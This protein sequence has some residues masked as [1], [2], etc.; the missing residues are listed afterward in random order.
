M[1][2]TW[3]TRE[4]PLRPVAA[5]ARG[6]VVAPLARAVA[7]AL[8]RG[9]DLSVAAGSDH[10]LVL[11]DPEAIP[12]VDGVDWLGRDG[13]LLLPTARQP[14]LSADL[15]AAAVEQRTGVRPI[16]ILLPDALLVSEVPV[17]PPDPRLLAELG[18]VA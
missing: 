7:S 15:V 3:R 17:G 16:Q 8:H 18:G 14:E 10:L 12:W 11:G 6:R 5:L 13:R 4:P 2:L 9:A 1:S